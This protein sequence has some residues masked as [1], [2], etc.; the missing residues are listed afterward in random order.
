MAFK[1]LKLGGGGAKTV[2]WSEAQK[3]WEKREGKDVDA[4]GRN[5]R[6]QCLPDFKSDRTAIATKRQLLLQTIHSH[7]LLTHSQQSRGDTDQCKV[8]PNL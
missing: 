1:R 6:L 2:L 5:T 3:K 4:E 7:V 8:R